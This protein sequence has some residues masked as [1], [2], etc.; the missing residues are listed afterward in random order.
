[1]SVSENQLF[2]PPDAHADPKSV[3]MVRAWIVD[4]GLQI[5]LQTA[6]WDDVRSWGILLAD[7][8]RFIADAHHKKNGLDRVQTIANIR[9]TFEVELDSPTCPTEGDFA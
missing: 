6:V 2:I 1:M 4:G 3:E 8:C 9:K 5:S 7:V